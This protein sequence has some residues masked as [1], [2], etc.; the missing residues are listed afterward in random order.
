MKYTKFADIP[1]YTN[2]GNYLVNIRP[3]RI[4]GYIDELVGEGLNL[5]PD[6]QRGHVWTDKQRTEYVEYALK[7]GKSGRLIYLNNP[8]WNR[9]VKDGCYNDFVIV[10]GKQRIEAWRKFIDNE[11]KAFDSYYKEYTDIHPLS[12]CETLEVVIND[13][14]TKA[15]VLRWYIDM[16]SCGVVHSDEEI[17]RVRIL[18]Q[19][20]TS[21]Q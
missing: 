20:E 1:Q 21:K 12:S 7:G 4:V 2:R 11:I 17:D 8:S 3:S 13:L 6:F 15:D 5:N 9:K 16:N 19:K 18:L 10:D 14:K